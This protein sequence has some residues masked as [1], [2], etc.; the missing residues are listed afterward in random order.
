MDRN[1]KYLALLCQNGFRSIEKAIHTDR[2]V[3]ESEA[4]HTGTKD[5]LLTD[6]ETPIPQND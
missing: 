3:K 2:K 6:T 4:L 1:V 5:S